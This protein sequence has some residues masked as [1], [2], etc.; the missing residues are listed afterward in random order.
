MLDFVVVPCIGFHNPYFCMHA[1]YASW[2][3]FSKVRRSRDVQVLILGSGPAPTFMHV[4]T[5][6]IGIRRGVPTMH[7]PIGAALIQ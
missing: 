5:F 1:L 6:M 4:H 2:I 3:T 7:G